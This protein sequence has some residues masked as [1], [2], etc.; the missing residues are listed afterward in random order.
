MLA[1][2]GLAF[3]SLGFIKIAQSSFVDSPSVQFGKTLTRPTSTLG[4]EA[5]LDY[6]NVVGAKAVLQKYA[7]TYM[8]NVSE[9]LVKKI[10]SETVFGTR[11]ESTRKISFD[12]DKAEK[13]IKMLLKMSSQ[14]DPTEDQMEKAWQKVKE[15]KNGGVVLDTDYS[16]LDFVKNDGFQFG[17]SII[18]V[19]CKGSKVDVITFLKAKGGEFK[20]QAISRKIRYFKQG[21]ITDTEVTTVATLK[22]SAIVD[23]KMKRNVESVSKYQ[24]MKELLE[25]ANN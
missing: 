21:R 16:A 10:T 17:L 6:K 1:L 19:D 25:F 24:L 2:A 8:P 9:D 15:C 23:D 14:S 18:A 4:A 5:D 13:A 3:I 12:A 22:I 11:K 7:K 20:K